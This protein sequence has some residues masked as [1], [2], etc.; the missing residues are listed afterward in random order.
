MAH[1]H[2]MNKVP[3]KLMHTLGA[4]STSHLSKLLGSAPIQEERNQHSRKAKGL[5][6]WDKVD[7]RPRQHQQKIWSSFAS[8]KGGQKFGSSKTGHASLHK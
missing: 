4:L 1:Y 5:I 6:L 7:A 2:E 8:A 3:H